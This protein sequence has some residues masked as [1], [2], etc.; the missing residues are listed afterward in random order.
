M[1][2]A[3]GVER[4]GGQLMRE[5]QALQG[6]T[7]LERADA[8]RDD[9]EFNRAALALF[10]AQYEANAPYASYCRR[11]G[12]T[13]S[14]VSQWIDI[15][16]APTDAFKR[17]P[18]AT[19]DP[20]LAVRVFMTS[21][22]SSGPEG[23]GKVYKDSAALTLH[24]VVVRDGFCR[25]CLPDR[26]SI[27]VLVL[28]PQEEAVPHLRMAHDC[29]LFRR[30]FDSGGGGHF[31]GEHGLE[32]E[33]LSAALRRAETEGSPVLLVGATFSLV[34]FFDACLERGR[35]FQLPA[36]SRIVDGGG[37]KGRS[38]ELTKAEFLE[39]TSETLGLPKSHCVNLLG[40]TEL[41]SLFFD[42]TLA[43]AQ[44][45]RAEPRRKTNDPWTRTRAVDTE[46]LEILPT[47]EVGLLRHWDLANVAS[48][49]VLQTDDLGICFPQADTADPAAAGGFEV[50]GRA[51]GAELRGC[52]L[53]MEQF[54]DARSSTGTG[55]E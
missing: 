28:A 45:G 21:G 39:P 23:R 3:R 47:G 30:E 4:S 17:E 9:A 41:T 19:F 37:Y 33:P 48:V 1:F 55:P 34:R 46:S 5:A 54:L 13:P 50:L 42:N 2:T 51:Q 32:V 53:A 11:V 26:M 7:V 16:A 18:L 20:S 6:G 8:L 35:R 24:D 27:R 29:S 14:D 40:I 49:A 31:V 10:A 38:R 22:T 43:A 36:G 44:A 12:R 15:P 52:S 25:W